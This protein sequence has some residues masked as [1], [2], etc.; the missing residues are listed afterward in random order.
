MDI[1]NPQ[2]VPLPAQGGG[3]STLREGQVFRS[4]VKEMDSG[5][6]VPFRGMRIPI[7]N[8]PELQAG[9]DVLLE[10]V[11]KAG[12]FHLR[13]RPATTNIPRES[14]ADQNL[15]SDSSSQAR[16]S[17]RP[18][19][20]QNTVSPSAGGDT[21]RGAGDVSGSSTVAG[22]NRPGAGEIPS[23]STTETA[24]TN[25]ARNLSSSG[26]DRTPAAAPTET[27]TAPM[28]VAPAS[29]EETTVSP[30]FLE[31]VLESVQA[32]LQQ[33]EALLPVTPEAVSALLPGQVPLTESVVRELLLLFAS[34][35]TLGETLSGLQEILSRAA[36][37]SVIDTSLVET[38]ALL[39]QQG[40]ILMDQDTAALLNSLTRLSPASAE[41]RLAQAV[42][43]GTAPDVSS[44]P[45]LQ[46]LHLVQR[47]QH[48]APFLQFL[49]SQGLAR[50]F[51][52]LLTQ[53][54]E[55]LAGS[56]VQ[57]LRNFSQ[58]YQFLELPFSPG[59]PVTAGQVHFFTDRTSARSLRDQAA[60]VVLDLTTRRLGALWIHLSAVRSTCSCTFRTTQPE[61]GGILKEHATELETALEKIGFQPARVRVFPWD[62]NR[63][64]ELATLLQTRDGISVTA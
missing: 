37:A 58:Q 18:S 52:G 31:T 63:L 47:L 2:P 27:A 45:M 54:Q 11:R 8:F 38:F 16:F 41:A 48:D 53:L 62:G 49:E 3:W 39:V 24:A 4:V 61:V 32:A 9:Q 50:H 21:S 33:E 20:G 10:V 64:R 17:G 29:A 55:R 19:P 22:M 51:Q 1:T 30:A 12:M 15:Q 25:T 6:F 34:R 59:G 40:E 23:R 56:A 42:V 28:E 43:N 26:N 46:A 57:Q 60:S 5:L 7:Q 13:V 14:V 44:E 35:T 36:S